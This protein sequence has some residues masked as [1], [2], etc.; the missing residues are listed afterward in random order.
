[1]SRLSS[2]DRFVHDGTY[3]D[4]LGQQPEE[5]RQHG[6]QDKHDKIGQAKRLEYCEAYQK[7]PA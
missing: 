1:M 2:G 5:A 7:H 4:S 3:D 6:S